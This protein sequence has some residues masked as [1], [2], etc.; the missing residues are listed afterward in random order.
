M[1]N[2]FETQQIH[3]NQF[4]PKDI[5]FKSNSITKKL[6][7]EENVLS[8]TT[9]ESRHN[10][11]AKKTGATP[12]SGKNWNGTSYKWYGRDSYKAV[13]V[14][15]KNV[16]QEFVGAN[17]DFVNYLPKEDSLGNPMPSLDALVYISSFHDKYEWKQGANGNYGRQLVSK[18]SLP[19]QE[20]YRIAYGGQGESNHLSASEFIE[21]VDVAEAVRMFLIERVLKLKRG[22]L[23]EDKK[24]EEIIAFA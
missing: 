22:L 11:L 19:D 9:K 10:G 6:M 16:N 13:F 20:G 2:Y 3:W 23:E 8:W 5:M 4:S 24:E 18:Q 1:Q 15:L 14:Q 21:I 12:H 7:P 17:L